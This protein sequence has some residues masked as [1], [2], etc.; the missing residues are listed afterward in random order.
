[1]DKVKLYEDLEKY[2][3]EM[4]ENGMEGVAS[5]IETVRNIIILD[6]TSEK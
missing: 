5:L 4:S 1:M 3:K 2:G 6:I